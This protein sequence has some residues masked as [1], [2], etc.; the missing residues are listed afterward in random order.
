MLFASQEA[1]EQHSFS[2]NLEHRIKD[3]DMKIDKL[4]NTYL[5]N[6]ISKEAFLKKKN[7]LLEQRIGLQEKLDDFGKKGL[8][9][10]ELLPAG[11]GGSF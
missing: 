11:Q 1:K 6:L 4:I 5:E 2:Q 8:V 7:E 3:L 10:F 9:W